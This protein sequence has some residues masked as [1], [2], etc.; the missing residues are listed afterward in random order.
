MDPKKEFAVR[1]NQV[2]DEHGYP[3]KHHGRQERLAKEFDVTPRTVSNWL[4]GEKLPTYERII[5]IC[6]R[7]NVAIDWLMTGRGLKRPLADQEQQ[8][9]QDLREMKVADQEKVYQVTRVWKESPS[10]RAA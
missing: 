6:K 9:I 2:L 4:N 10:D 8:H 3:T 5:E 7:Y 1:F